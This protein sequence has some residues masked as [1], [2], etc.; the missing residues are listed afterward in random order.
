[1]LKILAIAPAYRLGITLVF[2]GVVIALSIAPGIERPGDSIFGWLIFNTATPIQK[3]MHIVVYATLAVLWMWTLDPIE[4]RVTR[5]VLTL[6][7]TVGLGAVLEWHQTR[8]PGRFG[9]VADVVLNL[10]GAIAGLI[11]ALILL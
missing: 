9:T 6:S 3:A 8:V 2:V 1:M 11:A 5:I 10:I 4:S 7:L